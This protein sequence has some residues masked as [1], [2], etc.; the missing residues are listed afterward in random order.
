MLSE[1]CGIAPFPSRLV[2][3]TSNDDVPALYL[4]QRLGFVL[5]GIKVGAIL[6]HHGGEERGFA[7]I[8]VRDELQLERR[9][10]P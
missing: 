9:L 7:G 8:P 5:T 4:Y 1:V 2:V 10:R 3:A 6:R